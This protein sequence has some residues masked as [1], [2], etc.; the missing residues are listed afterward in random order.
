LDLS[1][2]SQERART[3]TVLPTAL[4]VLVAAFLTRQAAS[5]TARISAML[6]RNDIAIPITGPADGAFNSGVAATITNRKKV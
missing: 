3:V 4:A 6:E 1:Y 5:R 2:A